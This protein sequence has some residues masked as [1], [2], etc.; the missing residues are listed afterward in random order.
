MRRLL[1]LV[2]I[3]YVAG[4][5]WFAG[6][7]PPAVRKPLVGFHRDMNSIAHTDVGTLTD[8]VGGAVGGA[9]QT[10]HKLGGALGVNSLTV[11]P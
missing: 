9:L 1:A 6:R 3:F 10:P 5:A 7:L 2:A 8:E 11:R 4:F